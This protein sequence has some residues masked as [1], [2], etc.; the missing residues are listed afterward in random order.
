MRFVRL[1]EEEKNHLE[2]LYKTSS[3]SVVRKRCLS[4]LYSNEERSIKEV[5]GLMHISR[6]S[7]ERLLNAWDSADDKYIT[8]S[9]ASGRGAKVKLEAVKELL[10][11]LVKE[12]SR[13]LNPIL[14]E[15]QSKHHISV[16]KVT[17]QNFLKDLRL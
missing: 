17:L 2:Y 6:R 16:C 1:S 5:S 12:H 8:L 7:L 10:P 3:N 4:L 14:E 11:A 15:L 13:N 9:I